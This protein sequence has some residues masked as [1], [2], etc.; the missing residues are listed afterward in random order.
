M[1]EFVDD[2]R[3]APRFRI[4]REAMISQEVFEKEKAL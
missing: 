4:N 2:D 1:S 3:N